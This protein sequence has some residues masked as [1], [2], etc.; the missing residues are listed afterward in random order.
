MKPTKLQIALAYIGSI[1][2]GLTVFHRPLGLADYWEWI[3]MGICCAAWVSL[4]VSRRR[5]KTALSAAGTVTA[6]PPRPNKKIMWLSLV[7]IIATSLSS[8]LWLP[9]TGTAL[10]RGQLIIISVVN[11]ICCVTIYLF[12]WKRSHRV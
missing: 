4:F 3:F 2:L 6:T 7:L 11:C 8:F 9:Y 5:Q 1:C 12:A 10:P